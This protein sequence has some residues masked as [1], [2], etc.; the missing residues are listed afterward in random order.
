MSCKAHL[1]VMVVVVAAIHHVRSAILHARGRQ[2]LVHIPQAL[3]AGLLICSTAAH[4][5]N[6]MACSQKC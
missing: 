6:A 4:V 2:P 5:S 1:H 3:P